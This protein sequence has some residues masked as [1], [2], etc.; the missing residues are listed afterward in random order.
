[1]F[2]TRRWIWTPVRSKSTDLERDLFSPRR[3]YEAGDLSISQARLTQRR[4]LQH[5]EIRLE[6]FRLRSYLTPR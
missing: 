1:M 5:I 3:L 4:V 6:H 2:A